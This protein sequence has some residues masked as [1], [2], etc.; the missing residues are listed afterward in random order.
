[1]A[2]ALGCS[3]A[4]AEMRLQG[5]AAT[6]YRGQTIK[7]SIKLHEKRTFNDKLNVAIAATK[8]KGFY[9][10]RDGSGKMV[11]VMFAKTEAKLK[12]LMNKF[13]IPLKAARVNE[14]KLGEVLARVR[15]VRLCHE[16]ERRKGRE[17]QERGV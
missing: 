8:E 14:E 10:V 5:I 16:R 17:R 1:M 13:E 7:A 2:A 9:P 6:E 11:R 4:P 15:S 12:E 3:T